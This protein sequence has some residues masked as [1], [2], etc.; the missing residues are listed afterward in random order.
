M[1]FQG[2]ESDVTVWIRESL[3]GRE[4]LPPWAQRIERVENTP[5]LLVLVIRYQIRGQLAEVMQL[6]AREQ[7]LKAVETSIL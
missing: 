6:F 5:L 4:V 2:G 3:Q 1:K 7:I